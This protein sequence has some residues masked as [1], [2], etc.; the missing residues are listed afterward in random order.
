MIDAVVFDVDGVLVRSGN[1]GA[2]LL[3]DY[4]PQHAAI[5]AFWR[6]PF[7]QCSLGLSDL[8]QEIEP[9]LGKWGYRGTVED[10]LQAWFEADSAVNTTVLDEVERLRSRGIPCHLATT[11]ERYRAAYLEGPMGLAAR[12][13]RLFFSCHLGVRKPQPEFYRRVTD[14][15]GMSPAALLFFDDH[16]ANVDAARAAGWNAELY[17]FGDDLSALLARHGVGISR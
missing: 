15:L 4:G 14:E 12:F 3:R 2:Q 1:F 13:D 11:Q 9:F 8:K 17:T 6:G 10:C 7:V 5:D 16:H